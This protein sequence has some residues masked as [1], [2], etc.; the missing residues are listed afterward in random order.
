MNAG[1]TGSVIPVLVT[2]IKPSA[3]SASA[4]GWIPAMNAGM[5]G[6]VIP[7]LGAG[8]QPSACSAARWVPA[9]NAGMTRK[10]VT[11]AP[12]TDRLNF[13]H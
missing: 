3:C 12:A 5:T 8:I 10:K 6:S 2:G 13:T 4:E 7:V 11:A 9:M 1:M